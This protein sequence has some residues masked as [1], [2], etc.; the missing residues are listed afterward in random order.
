ME[1]SARPTGDKN[2]VTAVAS[3]TGRL[4]PF[5]VAVLVLGAAFAVLSLR[6]F[7]QTTR[8]MSEVLTEHAEAAFSA[9]RLMVLIERAGRA[10]RSY[11]IGQSP[12]FLSELRDTEREFD[13]MLDRARS[14]LLEE[15]SARLLDRAATLGRALGSA[16]S[17]AIDLRDT[18]ADPAGVTRIL[19]HEVQ[20]LR[21]ELT[22]VVDAL[23]TQ[24]QAAFEQARRSALRTGQDAYRL[25]M[26]IAAIAGLLAATLLVGL[27]RLVG[28]L[29]ASQ[30]QL[31]ATLR[32]L[33]QRNQDLDAF[34]GRVAHD[35][36]NIIAPLGLNAGRIMKAAGSN[37][38]MRT[39]AERIDRI[40]QKVDAWTGAMLAFA[41]SNRND[42]P[43]GRASLKAVVEDVLE[44]LSAQQ[45][46]ID[47][48]LETRLDEVEVACP[49][50]LL[51]V[52]VLNV[53]GN[54]YKFLEGSARRKVTIET[55]REGPLG[56]LVVSD[57]GPGIASEHQEKIFDPFHRVHA[58]PVSGTGIGLAT[59]RRIVEGHGGRVT[60]ESSPGQGA[61]FRIRLPL[62]AGRDADG[63]EAPAAQPPVALGS[64]SAPTAASEAPPRARPS[65]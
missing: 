25:L 53:I 54:A 44:T 60:V 58:G 22:N 10:S 5:Y 49:P 4:L 15:Q 45:S 17:R 41:R 19:E 59:V 43:R 56:E 38:Q 65:V 37:N 9:E 50:P 35:L 42:N 33:E 39:A 24:E 32:S 52:A 48:E 21:D 36:R 20:P 14:E 11:L 2:K 57:T 40:A 27:S 8:T 1:A 7:Q 31:D 18:A 29:G 62:E 63:G 34:A 61:R 16:T 6:Q 51:Q 12:R 30:R 26:T 3:W 13:V 46:L 47:V 23:L 55:H 28:R 64:A